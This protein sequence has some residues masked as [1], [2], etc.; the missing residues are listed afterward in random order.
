MLTPELAGKEMKITELRAVLCSDQ[1]KTLIDF[2][3]T[4]IPVGTLGLSVIFDEKNP[5]DFI[6]EDGKVKIVINAKNRVAASIGGEATVKRPTLFTDPGAA[7]PGDVDMAPYKVEITYKLE[8]GRAKLENLTVQDSGPI[9]AD[10]INQGKAADENHNGNG[11]T[12]LWRRVSDRGSSFV[13]SASHGAI[14]K[15][16]RKIMRPEIEFPVV[17]IPTKLK[18]DSKNLDKR[19]EIV[20]AGSLMPLEVF[21]ENGWLALSATLCTEKTKPL[22]VVFDKENRVRAV[23]PNSPAAL[24]GFKVGDRI[25]SYSSEDTRK[26]ALIRD[27]EPFFEFVKDKAIEKHSPQ[28]T[29][30]LNGKSKEGIPFSR[31]VT[32]CPSNMDHRKGAEELLSNEERK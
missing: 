31:S 17:S 13:R 25:E 29:I 27:L 15:E 10:L 3:D 14:E 19:A 1:I 18:V 5:I 2:C 7:G 4:K 23:Q 9:P 8:K 16:F 20:E 11:F 28:R 6:F 32:L 26:T 21:A 24:S 12:E 30:E 22:G